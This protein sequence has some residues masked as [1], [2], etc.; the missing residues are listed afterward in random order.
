MLSGKW[1]RK[2]NPFFCL[3]GNPSISQQCQH[4]PVSASSDSTRQNQP[5]AP[6]AARDSPRAGQDLPAS[7]LISFVK[8]G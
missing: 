3:L 6:A 5:A 8:P 2:S 7:E 4:L 1:L